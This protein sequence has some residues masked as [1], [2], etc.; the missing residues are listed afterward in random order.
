[1]PPFPLL[2]GKFDGI[3]GN[4]RRFLLSLL[5]QDFHTIGRTLARGHIDN[6]AF[7]HSAPTGF[8][9]APFDPA[10]RPRERVTIEQSTA[11]PNN[12]VGVVTTRTLN[13]FARG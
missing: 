8:F 7:P 3:E 5:P 12:P 9:A 2:W 11:R 4:D 13:D 10:A 1:M 6:K